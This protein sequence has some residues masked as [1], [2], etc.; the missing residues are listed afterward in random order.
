MIPTRRIRFEYLDGL[1]VE[2]APAVLELNPIFAA[3]VIQ[4]VQPLQ[5]AAQ[6][7]DGHPHKLSDERAL[8]A[9]A[10]CYAAG[11]MRGSPDRDAEAPAK[12]QQWEAWL[13]A[14]PPEFENIRSVAEVAS[15][16]PT[17]EPAAAALGQGG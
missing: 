15:N 11:A 7:P 5:L 17:E 8:A 1:E 14:N 2:F 9:L 6:L 10:K 3:C 13:L 16:F 4:W 12:P